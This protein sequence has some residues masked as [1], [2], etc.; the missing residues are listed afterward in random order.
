MTH[1]ITDRVSGRQFTRRIARYG[2]ILGFDA[3]ATVC[4]LYA[5]LLLRLNGR[6]PPEHVEAIHLAVPVLV[7]VRLLALMAFRLHRWSFLRSG[8]SEAARLVSAQLAGS[9]A[10][11]AISGAGGS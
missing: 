3:V 1:R 9:A 2:S 8:L 11:L 10:F 5:A 7:S 6:V 4:A